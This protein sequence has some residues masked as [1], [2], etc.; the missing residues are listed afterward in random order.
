MGPLLEVK[1]LSVFVKNG[2][3]RLKVV[4]DVDFF[5]EPGETLGIVGESGCGKSMTSSAIMRLIPETLGEID[6][7]SEILLNGQNLLNLSRKEMCEIRG[8]KIALIM[9]DSMAAL[10][11]MS[12]IGTQMVEML[13]AHQKISKKEAKRQAVKMLELVGIPDPAARFEDYPH[14]MSGG[15]KQ[16]VNIAIALLCSPQLLIADEPTTAL[17]V[18]VQA[19]ILDLLREM[20]EK[21]GT[22]ILFI[23]H[24][25][26]VMSEM[27]E[28]II[29][30]YAGRI[31]ES[32]T[33][34]QLFATPLHPYT[35]GLL[36]T[37]IQTKPGEDLE[38]IPGNVAAPGEVT[39]GCRFCPRCSCAK[40]ICRKEAPPETDINGQKVCCWLYSGK[41]E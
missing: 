22:S 38:S 7:H 31:V 24:D 30:M 39:E 16:R 14:Q 26:G 3:K 21:F 37:V 35:R 25:L 41:E 19:Q 20:K 5:I 23:T 6:D 8:N 2:K 1:N 32:C 9:Q 10:N 29:V 36:G 17:D 4:D 12:K 34:D 40:E 13:K 11:P 28:R 18:T 15:M 27:A 33:K